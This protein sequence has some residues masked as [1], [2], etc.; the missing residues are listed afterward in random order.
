M[1]GDGDHPLASGRPS[2]S[3]VPNPHQR[4]PFLDG[5]LEI[6]A[7][8]HRQV[9]QRLRRPQF[10]ASR[11]RS[12]RSTAKVGRQLLGVFLVG[13]HRHQAR[14][15]AHAGR[16]RSAARPGQLLRSEAVLVRLAAGVDLQQHSTGRLPCAA[17]LLRGPPADGRL[18]T[19]W[20]QVDQR[21]VRSILLRCRWPIRCQRT[22][23]GQRGRLAPQFLRPILAQVEHAQLR[24]HGGDLEDDGLGD[25][26][27]RHVRARPAGPAAG[28]A[29]AAL[30]RPRSRSFRQCVEVAVAVTVPWPRRSLIS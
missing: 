23:A 18:S 4:R 14:D 12:F 10:A 2:N 19:E 16:P 15:A 6:V 28:G 21:Q 8:A 17:R 3:T 22:P 25:G 9:R 29:R 5:H 11:S 26:D 7:H 1:V 13:R 27:Q 24:Q 30:P 20:M